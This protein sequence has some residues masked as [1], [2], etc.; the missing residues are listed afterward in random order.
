MIASIQDKAG[1]RLCTPEEITAY[2][3]EYSYGTLF[4]RQEG[5]LLRLVGDELPPEFLPVKDGLSLEEV[6]L[7]YCT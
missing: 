2:Q 7:Y 3:A 4:Q 1:D 5:Q 6:Y